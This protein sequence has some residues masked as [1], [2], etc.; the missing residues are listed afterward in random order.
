MIT[1]EYPD[2]L[3]RKIKEEFPDDHSLHISARSGSD[4]LV[5][6]LNVHAERDNPNADSV[7]RRE[8]ASIATKCWRRSLMRKDSRGREAA[9]E[10]MPCDP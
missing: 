6:R 2:D 9:Q 3:V 1:V 10:R 7:K 5:D 4:V 8:L